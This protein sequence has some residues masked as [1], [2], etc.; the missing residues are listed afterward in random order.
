VLPAH[1]ATALEALPGGEI[2]D[3]DALID[4]ISLEGL[5]REAA[6]HLVDSY[7]AEATAVA[8]LMADDASLRAPL[9]AGAP[10]TV[11]EIV[12]QARREM[13][14]TVSDVMIRRTH[15]FHVREGQ[16]VEAAPAVGA[17]LQKELG[18]TDERRDGSVRSYLAEVE[19][20]RAALTDPVPA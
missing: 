18:W 7:G 13:A 5:S 9:I 15:I 1:A 14:L 19:R 17:L 2:A 10:W 4:Q 8:K 6:R 12:Y 11:A 16:G 20:M 3:L